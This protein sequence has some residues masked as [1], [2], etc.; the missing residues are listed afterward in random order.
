MEEADVDEGGGFGDEKP[1]S[2]RSSSLTLFVVFSASSKRSL[3][4]S[5]NSLSL[6]TK[7]RK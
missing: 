4:E 6:A 5:E 3:W 1:R 2:I 7:K